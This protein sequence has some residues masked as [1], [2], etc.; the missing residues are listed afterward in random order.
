MPSD[1]IRLDLLPLLQSGKLDRKALAALDST[2]LHH[3][4]E[5][6]PPRN[7]RETQLI[8]IWRESLGMNFFGVRDD[9]F[10]LGGGS[11]QATRMFAQINKTFGTRLPPSTL[12]RAATI[13]SLAEIIDSEAAPRSTAES[14]RL[15]KPGRA[16][17]A[18]FLVHDG[19][20]V[21]LL[22]LNLV[23][24]LPEELAVYGIEPRRT[25]RHPILHTR[26]P[27]MAAYYVQEL[28]LAQPDGPYLLGGMWGEGPSRTRWHSNWKR[29]DTQSR[30]SRSL[31]RWPPRHRGGPGSPLGGA[32]RG[33][34]ARSRR[35]DG[36]CGNGSRP[37]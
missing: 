36:I 33:F 30:S 5:S 25:D 24:R 1:F 9:F 27:D 14:L 20:G 11:L 34:G 22:Y 21:T 26:I 19:V 23:R 7:D 35:R 12:I 6:I 28:R 18:L 8:A 2:G 37:D 4:A 13:E 3:A 32:G 29:A 17:P 10:Q 15:L 16:G 31:T